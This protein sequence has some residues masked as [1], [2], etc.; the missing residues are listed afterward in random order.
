MVTMTTACHMP[1]A[2]NRALEC[3]GGSCYEC[4]GCH[5][6]CVCEDGFVE[7][8][9]DMQGDTADARY[10]RAHGPQ[11]AEYRRMLAREAEEEMRFQRD[12]VGPLMGWSE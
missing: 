4:G 11:S 12:V 2:D 9:C 8:D 10:C 5:E 7:C 1:L 3:S 6:H